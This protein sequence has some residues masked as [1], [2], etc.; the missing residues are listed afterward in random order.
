MYSYR[1]HRSDLEI[2]HRREMAQKWRELRALSPALARTMFQAYQ[3]A[4]NRAIDDL[5]S[6]STSDGLANLIG[7]PRK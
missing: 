2:A 4:I 1:P 6:E 5:W 7:A 3:K